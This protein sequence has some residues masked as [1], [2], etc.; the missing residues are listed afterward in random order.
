MMCIWERSKDGYTHLR[1]FSGYIGVQRRDG[2][3]LD[4]IRCHG[5]WMDWMEGYMEEGRST[6]P[7]RRFEDIERY[8]LDY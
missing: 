4:W 5:S 1:A 6:Q 2:N 3:T 7:R 8:L